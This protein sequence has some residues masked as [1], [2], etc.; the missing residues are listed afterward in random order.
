MRQDSAE[1]LMA[2]DIQRIATHVDLTALS[3][4]HLLLT[5]CTGFFGKWLLV[6]L[7]MLNRNGAAIQVTAVSRSPEQ[8]LCRYPQ[9]ADAAWIRWLQ[10]DVRA[11]DGV[12]AGVRVD[13]VIH[14]A[15][16]TLGG[17]QADA[18]QLYDTILGGARSVL[19]LAVRS[20][21]RRVLFTGS[22]A[23]Y[24]ALPWGCPVA[25]SSA[26]ACDSTQ[27]ASAYAE[28]K[29]AQE[30]LA[31]LYAQRHGLEVVFTR[32]FAF[33]GPGLALDAHFAI[34]NFVRDA[35]YQDEL[36]LNSSGS[37][38]RS[39]L[40][41]ADLAVWLLALL[42]RGE[43]G[44]AYNVGSDKAL[45]IAELA[46]RVVARLAPGK[47]VRI[48]GQDA[49]AQARSYYVPDIAKAR[50]LGL[51]DWTTLDQSIDS[52]GRWAAALDR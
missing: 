35:L 26:R 18:L 14:A 52:M 41:G 21:A 32:C 2:Q 37:A 38:V 36:V 47:P 43:G 45:S 15:T 25:E 30:T 33:S 8:F 27:P 6:M 16:D 20:G 23:Q 48:L 1:A 7:A 24:G 40:Y 17:G 39:Y 19:E 29:R 9:Y 34:G 4:Q 12:L 5:G 50:A 10:A 46:H 22:G 44:Q 51:D 3:G 31:A 13:G 42:A 11:L 49:A 28:G